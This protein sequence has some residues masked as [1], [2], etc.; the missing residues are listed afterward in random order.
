MYVKTVFFPIERISFFISW[1]GEATPIGA[2]QSP[3]GQQSTVQLDHECT[4]PVDID[5]YCIPEFIGGYGMELGEYHFL[6]IDQEHGGP[7]NEHSW[8]V[9]Y[10]KKPFLVQYRLENGKHLDLTTI[11]KAVAIMGFAPYQQLTLN[12][13]CPGGNEQVFYGEFIAQ[14]IFATGPDGAL[15]IQLGQNS[16]CNGSSSEYVATMVEG[17]NPDYSYTY[18][19]ENFGGTQA[20]FDDYPLVPSRQ[21]IYIGAEQTVKADSI[22]KYPVFSKP[23][24][25]SSNVDLVEQEKLTILDGPVPADGEYWWSVS[26]NKGLRGWMFESDLFKLYNGY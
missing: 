11:A 21:W 19:G 26:T 18:P 10:P 2:L 7:L 25:Q 9:E 14:R 8:R 4:Y 22:N 1:K 5:P 15:Y 13:Y 16:A 12:F 17:Y 6:L 20:F 3:S 24:L 23:S